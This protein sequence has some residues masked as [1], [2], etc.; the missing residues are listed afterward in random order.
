MRPL[1]VFSSS[2]AVAALLATAQPAA[3]TVVFSDNF[4]G[5]NGG[6]GALN[7]NAFA[8]WSVSSGTVDLI[9]N[10]FFDFY[11]GNGLYVDLDGSTSQAGIMTTNVSFAP[12]SYVLTFLLGGN[13][14]HAGPDTVFI[15]FGGPVLFAIPV[16]D[17]DPLTLFSF[18]FTSSSGGALFFDDLGTDNQGAILDNVVLEQVPEPGTLLLLG[19]GLAALGVWRRR[20]SA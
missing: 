19:G 7:Y 4:N 14:R 16:Q 18:S 15:G 20:R 17:T 3:A 10:G 8:N 13:A 2:L 5:E 12:G 6:A 1:Q 11:P 9:G